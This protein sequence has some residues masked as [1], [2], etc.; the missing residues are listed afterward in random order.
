MKKLVLAATVAMLGATP[1]FAQSG[2][3]VG[4]PRI[5]AVVGWDR[6]V[7]HVDGVGSSGK[8]GVT[9]GG[10]IGYD[11][12]LSDYIIVGPYAGIDG[13]STKECI[14]GGTTTACLKAG[15]NITVGARFGTNIAKRTAFY[16]K[17][18]YSN[19]RMTGTITDTAV[20]A[21]NVNGHD[22]MDGF[23]IGTGVQLGLRDRI[24][25]K[26]EYNY[27]RYSSFEVFGDESRFDRH[28][29]VV[30]VGIGF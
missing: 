10:E 22:N 20:P 29:V 30:G 19:G 27:T 14:S 21:N 5:E 23:H 28:R 26:I 11:F 18:G 15:R 7:L 13:A 8:S 1:A 6:T 25:T 4:G 2:E 12:P 9:Y 16:I 17:G 3:L 24:Y